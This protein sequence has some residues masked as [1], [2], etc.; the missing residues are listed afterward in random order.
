MFKRLK[1]V[2][3]FPNVRCCAYDFRHT[4]AHKLLMNGGDVFTLQ[5]LLRHSSPVMTARYLAIWERLYKKGQA[6]SIPLIMTLPNKL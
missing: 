5:K 2:M 3:N 6:D 4:L 1:E